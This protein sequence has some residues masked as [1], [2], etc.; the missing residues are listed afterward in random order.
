ME[1]FDAIPGMIPRKVAI[2]RKRKE[3]S[4]FNLEELLLFVVLSGFFLNLRALILIK[5]MIRLNG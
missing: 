4:S 2:D 5:K 1:P 3:Y